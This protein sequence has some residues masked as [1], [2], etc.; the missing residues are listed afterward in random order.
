MSDTLSDLDGEAAVG[1]AAQHAV[2]NTLGPV[3]R[4]DPATSWLAAHA[5]RVRSGG[6]RR[7][8]LAH[9]ALRADLGSTDYEAGVACGLLRTA[10]G[11]RRKEL[12]NLGLVQKAG[13]TRPT[14]TESPADVYVLTPLGWAVVDRLERDAA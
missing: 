6:Q 3:H 4:D 14:D 8:V 2:A 12:A 11:T 5:N 7:R 10:A 9:L 13:F 1:L